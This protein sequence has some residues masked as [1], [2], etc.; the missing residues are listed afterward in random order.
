MQKD[1]THHQT[2]KGHNITAWDIALCKKNTQ[3]SPERA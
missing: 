1:K 2:L 3:S